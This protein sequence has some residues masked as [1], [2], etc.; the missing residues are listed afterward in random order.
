MSRVRPPP[1]V[2][3]SGV[4]GGVRSESPAQRRRWCSSC[5]QERVFLRSSRTRRP[6]GPCDELRSGGV[7]SPGTYATP[8]A[9]GLSQ[10]SYRRPAAPTG[11]SI[12]KCSRRGSG[13]SSALVR[14]PQKL[15]TGRPGADEPLKS[16]RGVL[17]DVATGSP[18]PEEGARRAGEMTSRGGIRDVTAETVCVCD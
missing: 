13:G 3:V 11:A 5:T 1:L 14:P 16:R 12:G 8:S 17:R 7:C 9:W 15:A 4:I 6:V 18:P 2:A 10:L